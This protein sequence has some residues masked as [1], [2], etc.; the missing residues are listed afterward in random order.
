MSKLAIVIA[1][2]M[3]ALGVFVGHAISSAPDAN[4]TVKASKVEQVVPFDLM[5]KS[6]GLPVESASAF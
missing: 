2:G 6:K 4:A 5:S 1:I 3:F